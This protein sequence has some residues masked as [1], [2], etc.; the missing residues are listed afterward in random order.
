MMYPVEYLFMGVGVLFWFRQL[1]LLFIDCSR[2]RSSRV[3]QLEEQVAHL[4]EENA[5]LASQA[6]RSEFR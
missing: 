6:A 1:Y 3:L 2:A 5:R 4:L